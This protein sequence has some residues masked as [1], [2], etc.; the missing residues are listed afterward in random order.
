MRNEQMQAH[1][2]FVYDSTLLL[3]GRRKTNPVG[4]HGRPIRTLLGAMGPKNKTLLGACAFVGLI[5]ILSACP[6]DS[7]NSRFPRPKYPS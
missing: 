2:P 3:H 4:G 6:C 1:V 5:V 7:R